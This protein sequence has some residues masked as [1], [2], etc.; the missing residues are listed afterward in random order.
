MVPILVPVEGRKSAYVLIGQTESL[1]RIAGPAAAGILVATVSPGWALAADAATYFVAAGFL[2]LVR[3]PFGE[4]PERQASVIGDFKVG[5]TFARALGWVIPASCCA[6]VYNALFSGSIG[7]LG[8]VIA[9]DTIGSQ[10][11][12]IAQSGEA[13]GLFVTGFFLVRFTIRRPMHAIMLGFCSTAVP[14]M[15]LGTAV[16]TVALAGAFLIAGVGLAVLNLAWSLTVQEKV[17]EEMLSR[18]MS[19]DGFF[20]FVAMPIGQLLVGPLILLSSIR[21]VELGSVVLAV[22]VT[23]GALAT[24]AIANLRLTGTPVA[25]DDDQPA[26]T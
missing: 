4:R 10:G 21:T 24:P 25:A 17:P 6:L 1:L 7:V 5:W 8:P 9:Q 26:T 11:W 2:V 14:M 23:V 22:V 3:I 16:S 19:I 15:V 12:G 20:S 18:I 13:V